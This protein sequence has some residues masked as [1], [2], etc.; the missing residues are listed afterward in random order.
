MK[1]AAN[2]EIL[3]VGNEIL[4]GEI[5]D[6]NTNWLCNMVHGLGGKVDGVT[7]L[8]D[9]LEIIAEAVRAAVNRKV[10]ILFT[11][12]GWDRH[13]MTSHCRLLQQELSGRLYFI[14]KLLKW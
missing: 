1:K 10:D 4:T 5:L 12:G 13:R 8:P 9:V 2:V 7:V 11:V 6:T 14:P 3:I